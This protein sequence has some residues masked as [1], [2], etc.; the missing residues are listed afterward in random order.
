[1]TPIDAV[2]QALQ[3]TKIILIIIVPA[4]VIIALLLIRRAKKGGSYTFEDLESIRV[5]SE[6][7]EKKAT[8][9]AG[10]Q[11]SGEEL[12]KLEAK[13]LDALKTKGALRPHPIPASKEGGHYPELAGISE[14]D[15]QTIISGLIDKGLALEGEREFSVV[16][17]PICGSCSQVAFISCKN[18][19]SL[20][21]EE[22]KYYR[23]TCGFVGPES[24]FRTET[25]LVCPQCGSS[26]NI[27][28]YY[29]R[30]KCPDCGLESEEPNMTFKCGSCGSLYD[31]QN[32]GIKT[33]KRIESSREMLTEYERV[34]AAI[35]AQIEFLRRGGYVIEKPANLVGE[36]GVIHRFEAVAKKGEEVIAIASAFG[37]PLTQ[38]LIRLGVAKSDLKLSKI[39]LVTSEAASSTEKDFA[40]SLGIELVESF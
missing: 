33:F 7:G 39:I 25:G 13:V 40:R 21:L 14:K 20:R 37:E 4:V 19:G 10:R 11:L 36:S 1:M 15:A 34:N 9:V 28:V 38:V 24:S 31:E 22:I 2:L 16:A 5:I 35:N 23:H 26:E 29:K 12:S 30:Y 8:I 32:M 27:E 3:G 6:E 17:C 18:C